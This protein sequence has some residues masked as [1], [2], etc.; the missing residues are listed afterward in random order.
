VSKEKVKKSNKSPKL[1]GAKKVKQIG[2]ALAGIV[3]ILA[4]SVLILNVSYSKKIFPKTIVGGVDLGGMTDLKAKE[5]LTKALEGNK[6]QKLTLVLGEKKVELTREELQVKYDLDASVNLAW[7]VGRKG[8]FWKVFGEQFR[9]IIG[10]NN[11]KNLVFSY[12][13]SKVEQIF[14][15]FSGTFS[16]PLKETTIVIK[17]LVPKVEIGQAGESVDDAKAIK[18]INSFFGQLEKTKESTLTVI[19]ASPRVSVEEAEKT[20][21]SVETIL[22]NEYKVKASDREYILKP[23][24]FAGW[25]RFTPTKNFWTMSWYLVISLDDKELSGFVNK[26]AQE[27][28]REAKDAKFQVSNGKV[29]TFQ[30]SQT[31]LKVEIDKAKTQISEGIVKGINTPIEITVDVVQPNV[32]A[33]SANTV[34]INEL[35]GEGKTSWRGSPKNRI[36]N[37]TLGSNKISGTLVKPGEEFSTVKTISPITAEAGFLPELVIKNGNEVEPEVGGGLC[38]VSTTLFRAV[39]N[40]GLEVVERDNHSFRVSYY[41]PPV[42]MDATIYDPKPDFRFKNNMKTPILL[43][44]VPTDN[45][46]TF[47]VYGTKDGRKTEISDPVLYNYVSPPDAVYKVKDTMA[48]DEIRQVERATRGVTAKFTYKVTAKNGEVLQDETFVSKYI[49]IADTF[50]VGPG[51]PIPTPAPATP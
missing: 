8:S 10:K 43:W 40:T 38:Q 7:E 48:A 44:A 17:D 50:F 20:L 28:D 21:I 51:Y 22:K 42:G 24:D 1:V 12:D 15:D 9:A 47:Q 5:E 29:T 45:G 31:G 32:S 6:D 16:K 14:S 25:L 33:N 18:T 37:L 49:P 39:L 46:L 3:V 2:L 27:V 36:H 13:N 4:V 30:T 41:E 19:E 26:I 11:T 23:A 35:I 34:G